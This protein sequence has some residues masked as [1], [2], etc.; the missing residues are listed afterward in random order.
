M[1]FKISLILFLSYAPVALSQPLDHNYKNYDTSNHIAR[2]VLRTTGTEICN[3][4]IDDDN[5][6]L[7]DDQD[8]A[9][10]FNGL[11]TTN[12]KSNSI[13]WSVSGNR[14]LYWFNLNTGTTHVVGQLPLPFLDITWASNG[15]LYGI[16]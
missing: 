11:T 2:S 1:K 10:Y 14:D 8:F 16:C 3:N 5:N 9:C 6:G 7:V 12:C 13:I 15:K 4:N